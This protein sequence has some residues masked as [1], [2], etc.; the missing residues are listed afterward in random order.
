VKNHSRG[1]VKKV[2]CSSTFMACPRAFKRTENAQ[3]GQLQRKSSN[4]RSAHSG[5]ATAMENCQRY[6]IADYA[7]KIKMVAV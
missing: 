3:D 4:V 6:H 1:R 5:K 7:E 2:E